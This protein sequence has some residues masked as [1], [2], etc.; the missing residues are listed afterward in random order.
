MTAKPTPAFGFFLKDNG[1]KPTT[2]N[3]MP[4]R[5]ISIG[6]SIVLR[7]IHKRLIVNHL[8]IKEPLLH[9]DFSLLYPHLLAQKRHGRA[10]RRR[11]RNQPPTDRLQQNIDPISIERAGPE[12]HRPIARHARQ[13]A[14]VMDQYARWPFCQQGIILCRPRLASI[15]HQ[16]HKVGPCK[17]LFALFDAGPFNRICG[18]RAS[19]PRMHED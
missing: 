15:G 2:L 4:R 17:T 11:I 9:K 19:R 3:A 1:P 18:A 12:S 10:R 5:S 13:I 7:V 6:L 16:H 14:L 8:G